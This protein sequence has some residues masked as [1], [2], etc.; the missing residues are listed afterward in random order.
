MVQHLH[1]QLFTNSRYPH[2]IKG[3]SVNKLLLDNT[4]GG[5][6]DVGHN[7]LTDTV[8]DTPDDFTNND[9]FVFRRRYIWNTKR[10]NIN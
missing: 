7:L 5:G 1:L 8:Q 9:L 2:V 3:N 10:S 4:D 6:V